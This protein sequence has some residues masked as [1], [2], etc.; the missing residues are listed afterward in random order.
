MTEKDVFVAACGVNDEYEG[1][2][3][4][5]IQ[6]LFLSADPSKEEREVDGITF[7][8]VPINIFRSLRSTIIDLQFRDNTDYDFVRS[9]S[10]LKDFCKVENSM[11]GDDEEIP[12]VQLTI[13]PKEYEGLYYIVGV[14]GTWCT[15]ADESA[16]L[17]NILRF[18]FTNDLVHTYRISDSAVDE[19]EIE[20]EVF[21]QLG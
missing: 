14:H 4:S 1:K 3:V 12:T 20:N 7:D 18:I 8:G 17:P 13:M 11:G 6:T 21:A 15:M 10:L 5:M 19:E 16:K 9:V 2:S